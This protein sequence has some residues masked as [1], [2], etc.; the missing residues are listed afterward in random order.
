EPAADV[1]LHRLGVQ[2]LL[3]DPLDQER[4][5]H[6]ALA[7][8]GDPDAGGEIVGGMLDRVVDVVRRHLDG[9]LDLVV[10]DLLHDIC[11]RRAI[12]PCGYLLGPWSYNRPSADGGRTSNTVRTRST[13]RR[14]GNWSTWR[15]TRRITT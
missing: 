14:C 3:A 4:H 11:H 12:R 1:A 5:R 13:R 10:A 9:E 15:A 2:A 7:E 8:A 6:L